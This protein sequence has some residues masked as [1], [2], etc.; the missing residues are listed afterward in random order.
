MLR[1]AALGSILL[2]HAEDPGIVDSLSRKAIAAGRTGA[3]DFIRSR[4]AAAELEAISRA[5]SI[6]RETPCAIHIV[7]GSTADAI[8]LIREAQPH[9]VDVSGAACPPH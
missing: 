9:G 8:H 3:R 5:I 1:I 2:L 6:A 4:P 7:H